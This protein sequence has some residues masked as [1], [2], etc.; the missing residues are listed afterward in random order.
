MTMFFFGMTSLSYRYIA[1]KACF[2]Y[3]MALKNAAEERED[4]RMKALR[5]AEALVLKEQEKSKHLPVICYSII[6]N[7]HRQN[8]VPVKK[9]NFRS[10]RPLVMHLGFEEIKLKRS[11]TC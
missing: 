9:V 11:S 4:K 10:G 8:S 5:E 2:Q 7:R 6:R 1:A 3:S